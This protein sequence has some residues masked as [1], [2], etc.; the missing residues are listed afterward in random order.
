MA[1][2]P[3]SLEP[4]LS[5]NFSRVVPGA[6]VDGLC[7]LA[8]RPPD[9][10]AFHLSSGQLNRL[11]LSQS[12]SPPNRSSALSQACFQNHHVSPALHCFVDFL[13]HLHVR[14]CSLSPSLLLAFEPR[15]FFFLTTESCTLPAVVSFCCSVVNFSVSTLPHRPRRSSS[16][17]PSQ[18]QCCLHPSIRGSALWLSALVHSEARGITSATIF[19]L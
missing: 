15:F 17:W 19:F 2:I 5:V 6:E 8:P 3:P 10:T 12:R 11:S 16:R 13:L 14:L 7:T 1:A 9:C 18:Q 4:G